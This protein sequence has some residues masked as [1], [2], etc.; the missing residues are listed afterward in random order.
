MHSCTLNSCTQAHWVAI[1]FIHYTFSVWHIFIFVFV[2]A[3]T[4]PNVLYSYLYLPYFFKRCIPWFVGNSPCK[5]SIPKHLSYFCK[6][7]FSAVEP[8]P[9]REWVIPVATVMHSCTLHSCTQ[10]HWVAIYFIH[11]TFSVWRI[12]IFVFVFANNTPNV[13]YSYL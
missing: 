7:T 8:L 12:F 1:Y 11:Y 5:K 4:S 9:D 3:N 13:L 10:A 2:F 6:L